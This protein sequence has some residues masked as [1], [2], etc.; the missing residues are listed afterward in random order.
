M[1]PNWFIPGT[2]DESVWPGVSQLPDYKSSF[3]K[4]PQQSICSIVPHLT[5]DGLDLMAVSNIYRC[6]CM[7]QPKY[8]VCLPSPQSSDAKVRNSKDI[9]IKTLG[10]LYAILDTVVQQSFYWK[11]IYHDVSWQV[12]V[13]DRWRF[14]RSI[15]NLLGH[16]SANKC[17]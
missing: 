2:P 3:P 11:V 8:I 1:H 14:N 15:I 17:K 13:F 7:G 10:I 16:T 5:G 4:W 12:I 9:L 6:I